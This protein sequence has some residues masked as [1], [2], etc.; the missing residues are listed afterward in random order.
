M[1][2]YFPGSLE[3][4]LIYS[5]FSKFSFVWVSVF[6]SANLFDL[7]GNYFF[8]NYKN[9]IKKRSEDQKYF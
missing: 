2:F 6:F 8:D 1:Q 5:F 3:H 4:Y 9:E 7:Y